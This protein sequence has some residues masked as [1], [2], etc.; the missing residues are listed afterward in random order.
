MAW[1]REFKDMS[2]KI[3]KQDT[4]P[5]GLF[6]S[7]VWLGLDHS[8]MEVGRPLIFESMVFGKD[9]NGSD[10]DMDRY[11]TESEALAGHKRLIEKW[12]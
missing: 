12:L 7:T 6:I 9:T 8:F 2:I 4:L 3:V 5:N 1:A 10:I 11:S